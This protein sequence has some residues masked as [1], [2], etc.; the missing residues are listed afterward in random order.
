MKISSTIIGKSLLNWYCVLEDYYAFSTTNRG[1]LPRAWRKE[2]HYQTSDRR[3]SIG[4][5]DENPKARVLNDLW[6][7]YR[8][9]VPDIIDVIAELKTLS[10]LDPV[11]KLT[12]EK[13]LLAQLQIFQR[14]FAFFTE[15]SE[16]LNTLQFTVVESPPSYLQAGGC[17]PA[18]FRSYQ[19]DY[20]PAGLLNLVCN[21]VE[22]IVR[23]V[24]LPVLNHS[25]SDPLKVNLEK[26]VTE[27][28]AYEVCQAYAGLEVSFQNNQDQMIPCFSPL[29]TA[30]FCCPP[31]LRT[32]VWHKLAH[33]EQFFPTTVKH[34]RKQLAA[35]W[36]LPTLDSDGFGAW[37]K[38]PPEL[39]TDDGYNAE[40]IDYVSRL[41]NLK[42][43]E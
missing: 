35:M 32:W 40:D 38:R 33:Y 5:S 22:L 41:E 27:S 29:F 36:K 37:K 16:F 17:P 12:T 11:Q 10:S 15:S 31:R 43:S 42:L 4:G 6:Q 13:R 28:Y 21:C 25:F 23:G 7:E 39:R 9:M 26:D 1:P 3:R 34:G 24:Y 2:R 8:A 20:P 14:N 30:A 19:F 18:P